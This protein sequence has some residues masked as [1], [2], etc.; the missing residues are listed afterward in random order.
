M[1]RIARSLVTSLIEMPDLGR[2]I[3]ALPPRSFAGLV[4]RIGVEDAGELIA[5][6]TTD[7]LVR[8]FDEDL[9]RAERAGER[10]TLDAGRF[11]VWLEVL[12]EAGDGVAADRVAEL[13]EAFVTHAL[14][15]LVLVLDEDALRHAIDEADEDVSRHVDKRLESALT[16]ELDGYV[17][18]AKH[19]DGWDAVLTLILALDRDHRALLVRVL[20]RLATLAS[21]YLDDLEELSGLLTEAES[22]AEDAEGAREERRSREGYVE[23][24]AARAFLKLARDPSKEEAR[25]PLTR[26]YFRDLE[27]A[28]VA[29]SPTSPWSRVLDEPGLVLGK[30]QSR[31]STAMSSF[32]AA[33]RE[34]PLAMFADRMDELAYLVNVLVAGHERDGMRMRPKEAAD[35]VMATVA[36]GA[37]IE[38]GS[39][40]QPLLDVLRERGADVLFRTASHA[41]ASGT[42]TASR[43]AKSSGILY[44]AEELD[45]AAKPEVSRSPR[46]TA[47]ALPSRSARPRRSGAGRT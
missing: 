23:A 26:A 14:S 32:T 42:A 38:G 27:R 24:R 13:D 40:K 4:R 31:K 5:H 44:S 39:K 47:G 10:E 6:A 41:L 2:A 7:Q 8:A 22:L 45:S 16:E 35:A 33:L 46:R 37:F 1:T 9:F 12:L 17:L 19:G 34:L 3:A 20:D 29:A 28:P 30:S 18:V 21:A 25:D 11:V 43:E 36:L 15:S